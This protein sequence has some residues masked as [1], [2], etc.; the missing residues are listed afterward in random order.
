MG[1]AYTDK[2]MYCLSDIQIYPA[3]LYFIWQPLYILS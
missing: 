2:N 1:Q 3:V